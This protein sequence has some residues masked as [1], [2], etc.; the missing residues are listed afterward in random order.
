MGGCFSFFPLA[1]ALKSADFKARPMKGGKAGLAPP[2][3]GARSPFC[4]EAL[5]RGCF[6]GQPLGSYPFP[7]L[8][9]K[10]EDRPKSQRFPAYAET[11]PKG[12]KGKEL[13]NTCRE[14]GPRQ[15][16]NP[17]AGYAPCL[18]AALGP[19]K[20]QLALRVCRHAMFVL[21]AASPDLSPNLIPKRN[22]PR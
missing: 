10:G 19:R 4:R 18:L 16:L 6:R 3:E 8:A 11:R 20:V 9:Y 17:Q 5:S 14:R 7:F 21:G 22:H 12:L 15:N 13:L 1:D 2:P